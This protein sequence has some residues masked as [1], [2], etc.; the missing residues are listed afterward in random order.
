MRHSARRGY[1]SGHGPS[2][3]SSDLPWAIGAVGVTVPACWFILKS[4][5]KEAH[6]LHVPHK[7]EV[8][9]VAEAEEEEEPKD[10]EVKAEEPKVEETGVEEPKVE[11]AKAETESPVADD[12]DEKSSTSSSESNTEV[13]HKEVAQEESPQDEITAKHPVDLSNSSPNEKSEGTADSSK[14]TGTVDATTPEK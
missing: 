8:H 1:S 10:V 12:E 11:D 9:E 7:I 3:A 4:S 13:D 6:Q 14:L 5:P 2:E